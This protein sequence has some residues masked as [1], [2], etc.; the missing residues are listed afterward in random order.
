LQ[1][2]KFK[3]LEGRCKNKDRVSKNR[4]TS[5]N[6]T[7]LGDESSSGWGSLGEMENA[8]EKGWGGIKWL[9]TLG[10]CLVG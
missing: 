7:L 6:C 10:I 2:G 1:S 9:I 8:Y 4:G 5:R 3:N